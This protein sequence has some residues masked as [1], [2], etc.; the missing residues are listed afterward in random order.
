MEPKTIGMSALLVA[1][2]IFQSSTPSLNQLQLLSVAQ[3]VLQS[4]CCLIIVTVLLS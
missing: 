4:I 2:T 1:C 3:P